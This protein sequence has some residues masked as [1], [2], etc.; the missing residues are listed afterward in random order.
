MNKTIT[1]VDGREMEVEYSI[2]KIKD[3]FLITMRYW[4][5][6]TKTDNI[7]KECCFLHSTGGI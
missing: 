7:Y 1:I 4:N 3:G 5:V 6:N 2:S